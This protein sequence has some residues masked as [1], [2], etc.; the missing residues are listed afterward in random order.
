MQKKILVI[1]SGLFGSIVAHELKK[2]GFNPFVIEKRAHIGGNCYTEE[3]NGIHIHKYGPHIFHT[4]NKEIWNW[5]NHYCEMENFIFSPVANFNDELFSLPFNLW[6]FYQL[7]GISDV[8]T[9]KKKIKN[10]SKSIDKP[11]NLEEQAISLVGKDIYEKLIHGYTKKQ[12]GTD[13][14]NLPSFIIK[15]LPVRLT[16]N[17]NYF[18][19][20]FQGIPKNGYTEIFHNLLQNIDVQLNTDF[21]DNREFYE[22]EFDHIV[23]SGPIDKLY[24]YKYGSLDYRSLRWEEEEMQIDNY[25]GN[26]VINYTSESVD[27]TRII[28]HKH[29]NRK[30]V[31]NFTI[32][33][34]E[35]PQ[36]YS[37]GAEPFYPINNDINNS[38]YLK[39]KTM[40]K[41]DLKYTIGG[42]LGR[43]QYYDMHQ[44]IAAALNESKLLISKIK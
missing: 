4:N 22:Q 15:R 24:D 41:S 42:R 10:Q 11:K 26:S 6:T 35:Y 16:F 14:V 31:E 23:Y 29:F 19:D 37:E 13:P 21:F 8:D 12:W 18:N 1:G 33:S 27:Y 34:K 36:D 40:A 38:I 30:K 32:I 25:Q 17:T 20:E 43:Y 9:I 3:T 7:W 39:Y 44:V 5:I 2:N 28:E